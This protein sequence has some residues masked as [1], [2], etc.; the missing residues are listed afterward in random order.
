[1]EVGK[2]VDCFVNLYSEYHLPIFFEKTFTKCCTLFLRPLSCG[3]RIFVNYFSFSYVGG[4]SNQRSTLEVPIFWFIHNEPLL[5][6]KHY[7]AKALS[8]M[9][10]VVQSDDDAWES[11]LQCNGKPILW[12]LR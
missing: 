9:I 8:N 10:V 11:H 4:H 12:D 1:M 3:M 2:F 7:Q 6:D 5:L